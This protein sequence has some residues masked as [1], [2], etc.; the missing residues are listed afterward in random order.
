MSDVTLTGAAPIDVSVSSTGAVSV[1]VNTA[2]PNSAWTQFTASITT[3]DPFGAFG[4]A[5]QPDLGTGATTQGRYTRIGRTIFGRV[6]ILFGS[7]PSAGT[8]LYQINLPVAPLAENQPAGVGFL[9][10]SSDSARVR[11]A[12]ASIAPGFS[13]TGILLFLE[14]ATVSTGANPA[15]GA[16]PWTWAESDTITVN[17]FYEAAS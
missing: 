17:F 5:V 2:V 7:S 16:S 15:G 4:G 6:Y 3:I 1:D 9:V 10:D 11:I 12:S 14:D 13:S 8:G